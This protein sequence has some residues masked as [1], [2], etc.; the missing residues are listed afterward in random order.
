MSKTEEGKRTTD[1]EDWQYSV[2]DSN[3]VSLYRGGF[4]GA[5]GATALPFAE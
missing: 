3:F 2:S 4:R 5:E 1:E